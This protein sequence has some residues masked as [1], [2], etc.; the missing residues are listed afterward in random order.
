MKSSDMKTADACNTQVQIIQKAMQDRP[1]IAFVY[2][3]ETAAPASRSL[4]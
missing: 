4:S 3:L 2:Y 1:A